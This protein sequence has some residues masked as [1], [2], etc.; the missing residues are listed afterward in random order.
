MNNFDVKP[1]QKKLGRI[2]FFLKQYRFI[3]LLL[4][5]LLV[6]CTSGSILTTT[7]DLVIKIITNPEPPITGDGQLLIYITKK[8]GQ[9]IDGL[10][11]S[12]SVTALGMQS[13]TQ[14]T[15]AVKGGAG[16]YVYPIKFHMGS[17]YAVRLW[18]YRDK[19]VIAIQ[20]S[21]IVLR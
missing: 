1:V 6:S 10:R 21:E 15:W 11:V 4:L 20:D 19:D 18:V 2:P 7:E 8:D 3:C 12:L 9:A 13:G 14:D 16:L 5:I 17:K